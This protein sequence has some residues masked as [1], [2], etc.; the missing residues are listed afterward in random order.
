M[1]K[2]S[3]FLVIGALLIALAGCGKGNNSENTNS[4]EDQTS[5]EASSSEN[6]A[7]SGENTWPEEFSKWDV[8]TI[9]NAIITFAD[10]KSATSTGFT[11]GITAVVNL[12]QLSKSDFDKY[13][14]AL[15]K[16]GFEKNEAESVGDLMLVYDKSVTGGIIKMTIMYAEDT[17]TITVNNSA[18]AAEKDAAAGGSSDWPESVKGIPEFTKG[19]YIETVEMGGGM[20][21]INFK[22][23]TE[24]DLD[25]YRSTLKSAGFEKQDSEDTEGYAKF[26]AEK[27]YS[28]GFVLEGGKLQIIVLSSSY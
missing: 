18:A 8:P 15:E 5:V 7:T 25:W 14:A 28:V 22:D 16:K 27:A 21:A 17:T 10:N 23:V 12:K 4:S 1:K 6:E 19:S 26:D 11:Q 20:Y 24:E 13:L 3:I 9:D 2:L